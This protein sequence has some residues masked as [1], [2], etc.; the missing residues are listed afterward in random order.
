[1]DW[2]SVEKAAKDLQKA[3]AK[4]HFKN[5]Q[6]SLAPWKQTIRKLGDTRDFYTVLYVC[7]WG[8]AA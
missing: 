6:D 5:L 4:G 2:K 1:M 7:E 3:V 8:S